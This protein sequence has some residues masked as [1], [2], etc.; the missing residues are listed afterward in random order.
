MDDLTDNNNNNNNLPKVK[1][2]KVVLIG[3][4]YVGKTTILNTFLKNNNTNSTNNTNN[5]IPTQPTIGAS[6]QAYTHIDKD[7]EIISLDI[8]DTAGQ[9]RFRSLTPMYLRGSKAVII[10]FDITN[11]DSFQVAMSWFEEVK[12]TIPKSLK[13]LIGNK[14]DLKDKRVISE[15]QASLYSHKNN[16]VYMET[17][18]LENINIKEVFGSVGDRLIFNGE[19]KVKNS[20]SGGDKANLKISEVKRLNSNSN[21]GDRKGMCCS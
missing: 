3:D 11:N 10:V 5:N 15:E 18:A 21:S 14:I 13:I 1:P 17:S 19:H 20:E 7:G 16:I 2:T 8:W 6:H 4:S 12:A 9:E